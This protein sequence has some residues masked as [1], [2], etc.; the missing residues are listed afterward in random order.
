VFVLNN[1]DLGY[2]YRAHLLNH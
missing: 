1:Y 2:N